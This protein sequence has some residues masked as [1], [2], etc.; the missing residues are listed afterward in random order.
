MLRRQY[1]FKNRLFNIFNV[2]LIYLSIYLVPA[3]AKICPKNF[4]FYI[5]MNNKIIKI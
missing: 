2:F 4:Y 3:K 5:K 1:G